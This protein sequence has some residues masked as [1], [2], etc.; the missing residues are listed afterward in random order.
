MGVTNYQP[1]YGGLGLITDDT[2][3]T[4]FTADG[5]LCA[6]IEGHSTHAQSQSR[7]A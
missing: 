3:M 7:G 5:L 4:L 2:Q 1:A 6:W